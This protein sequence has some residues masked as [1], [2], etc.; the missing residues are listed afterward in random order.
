MCV[1][2]TTD[3]DM[4]MYYDARPSVFNGLFDYYSLEPLKGYYPFY[5][6]GKFYDLKSEI[7]V[8][9]RIDDIY[10]LCGSREAG[11]ILCALTYYI[12]NDYAES[13]SISLDFGRTGKY[14]IYILDET[15]DAELADTTSKLSFDLKVH[16]CLLIEEI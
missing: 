7:R 8:E 9:N 11:K 5:W 12:D 10:S 16:Q 1:A 14:N 13:K 6:Y 4:L 3:I 2:Q 15:H